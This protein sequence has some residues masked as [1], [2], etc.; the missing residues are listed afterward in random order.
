MQFLRVFAPQIQPNV[1]DF[2]IESA[3]FRSLSLI[4][5]PSK[6]REGDGCTVSEGKVAV[7]QYIQL[8]DLSSMDH[9]S[10]NGL[11]AP[12]AR[13]DRCALPQAS[14]ERSQLSTLSSPDAT[15]TPAR[16]APTGERPQLPPHSSRAEATEESLAPRLYTPTQLQDYEPEELPDCSALSSQL[17]FK[18]SQLPPLEA[19]TSPCKLSQL[20]PIFSLDE[21]TL[22]QGS[23]LASKLS[24]LPSLSSADASNQ[25]QGSHLSMPPSLP[26]MPILQTVPSTFQATLPSV[27]TASFKRVQLN[28]PRTGYGSGQH[29]G[30]GGGRQDDGGSGGRQDGAGGG[31]R[32]DDRGD[33]RKLNEEATPSG[34]GGSG[35]RQVPRNQALSMKIGQLQAQIRELEQQHSQKQQHKQQC[36]VQQRQNKHFSLSNKVIDLIAPGTSGTAVAATAAPRA[37]TNSCAALATAPTSTA[38]GRADAVAIALDDGDAVICTD[39]L[40][41]SIAAAVG[42]TA[43]AS[44][45]NISALLGPTSPA[46]A[47]TSIQASPSAAEYETPSPPTPLTQEESTEYEA[48]SALIELLSCTVMAG[49]SGSRHMVGVKNR[50]M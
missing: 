21:T 19:Q 16:R 46:A 3:Y 23:H 37:T 25:R 8:N 49:S 24:Q 47:S 43:A 45:T 44:S 9:E 1:S 50:K 38:P 48:A 36:Q 31:G 10:L 35:Q 7:S 4:D 6:Q 2:T 14:G 22:T 30:G 42:S 27:N 18:L 26:F 28:M 29:D 12:A 41:D 17:P 39:T 13:C 40:D 11:E 32:Q 33:G 15:T 20:P 34:G 5:E